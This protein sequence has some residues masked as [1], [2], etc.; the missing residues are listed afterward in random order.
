M[1][2]LVIVLAYYSYVIRKKNKAMTLT[3][4]RL[5]VYRG[6]LVNN[7]GV[8]IPDEKGENEVAEAPNDEFARFLAMDRRIVKEKLYLNPSFGREDLMRLLGVDKNVLP[9]IL[10]RYTGTNVTGYIN[11]KRMEY[12]VYLMKY[13]P[14]YTITGIAESCGM[15]NP[16]T[17]IRNFKN[18]YGMTPSEYREQAVVVSQPSSE[19]EPQ[20]E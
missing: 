1:A 17:F 16:S 9:T 18:T 3:I 7:N 10:S 19:Q 12:A 5:M 14:E 4:H 8:D 2:V 13:H 11:A 15:A 6:A 20:S